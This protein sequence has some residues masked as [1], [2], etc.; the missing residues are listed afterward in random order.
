MDSGAA[1]RASAISASRVMWYWSIGAI[2]GYG[3]VCACDT[4][5][6]A[7]N[8]TNI[9]SFIASSSMAAFCR[10]MGE[11]VEEDWNRQMIA[12]YYVGR[13]QQLPLRP[14]RLTL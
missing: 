10:Y 7:S 14:P 6:I 11:S 2:A 5:P 4:V 8:R 3:D 12:E 1:L 13:K 9:W